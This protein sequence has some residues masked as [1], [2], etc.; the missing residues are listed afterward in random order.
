MDGGYRYVKRVSVEGVFKRFHVY[1]GW[2]GVGGIDGTS[3][4]TLITYL[5]C[6]FP[7]FKVYRARVQLLVLVRHV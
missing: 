6:P 1:T 2:S 4:S 5:D 7:C 3:Q